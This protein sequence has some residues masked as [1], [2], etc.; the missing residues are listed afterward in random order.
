MTIE[1]IKA[2]LEKMKSLGINTDIL[3]CQLKSA[4]SAKAINTILEL[5]NK[6][7]VLIDS[8]IEDLRE[9]IKKLKE[10]KYFNLWEFLKIK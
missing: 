9:E 8:D 3:E 5:T 1:E 6:H 4:I 7:L 10:K 2:N